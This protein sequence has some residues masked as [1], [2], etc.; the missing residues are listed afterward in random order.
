MLK[1]VII[2]LAAEETRPNP[3][4]WKVIPEEVTVAVLSEYDSW[5]TFSVAGAQYPDSVWFRATRALFDS[6][7]SDVPFRSLQLRASFGMPGP[8]ILPPPV[9][10]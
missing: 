6:S 5:V 3:G 10:L 2:P 4:E 1:I 9:A 8:L 7:T